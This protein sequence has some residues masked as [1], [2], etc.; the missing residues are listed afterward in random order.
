LT[1]NWAI[2]KSMAENVLSDSLT[3]K[4]MGKEQI[5]EKGIAGL[6]KG[7]NSPDISC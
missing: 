1:K 5:P 4:I 7:I 6:T 2:M 3:T